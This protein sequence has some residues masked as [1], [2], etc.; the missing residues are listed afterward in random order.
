M[1]GAFIIIGIVLLCGEP[2][3]PP[4]RAP[5]PV[6]KT[7]RKRVFAHLMPWFETKET[8][9]PAGAWGIHWTMDTRHPDS[10]GPDG[11]RQI[12]SFYYPL[13]GPYASGDPD[14]IEYQLLL[15]KYSGIDGVCIDW[16]GTTQL[17][18]YPLLLRNTERI[19]E[20]IGKIGLHYAIVYEDQDINIAYKKGVVG[21]KIAAAQADMRYLQ[22]HYFQDSNYEHVRGNPLL[23]DFGP[24]TFEQ[25]GQWSD[26]FSALP[27]PPAFFTLWDHQDKAGKNA[28]GAFAWINPDNLS[29]LHRFYDQATGTL[30]IASAYPGFNA[31]YQQGGWGGPTFVIKAHGLDNFNKTLDLALKSQ[32]DYVQLPTWNDYGEGTMIEPTREFQYG[33][34]TSLQERLGVP[35]SK[36]QLDLVAR[37]YTLRKQYAGNTSAEHT[38]DEAAID[39]AALRPEQAAQTMNRL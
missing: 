8:N 15:M 12:A 33:F 17:Y 5:L 2:K 24:Q 3:G 4:A 16:P 31:Y 13:T 27:R 30:F 21:D 26:I 36:T 38:L 20:R 25:E 28:T 32:A 35:F 29:S 7:E 19:I 14:L 6:Q 1:K 23:L 10:L 34:L 18:D 22:A 9:Q 37:L 11:R 39:L